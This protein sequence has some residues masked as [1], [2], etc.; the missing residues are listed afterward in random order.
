MGNYAAKRGFHTQSEL[1]R[2]VGC[3]RSSVSFWESPQALPLPPRLS[4]LA[5]LLEVSP[6]QLLD[7]CEIPT[8]HGFHLAAYLRQT[9]AAKALHLNGKGT[10]S[11]VERGRQAIPARWIPIL[12][13]LFW[14]REAAIRGLSALLLGAP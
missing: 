5:S 9:D 14:Q 7:E 10:S 8:L 13:R 3:S 6:T 11:D 1:A 4:R 12:A 2:A